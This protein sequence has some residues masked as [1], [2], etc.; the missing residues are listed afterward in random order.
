MFLPMTFVRFRC[1]SPVGPVLLA[2]LLAGCAAPRVLPPAA[3]A[4]PLPPTLPNQSPVSASPAPTTAPAGTMTT[5]PT[6]APTAA[7]SAPSAIHTEW[8]VVQ[9]RT[10][11][12]LDRRR[13]RLDFRPDGRLL[14]HTSCNP[15]T[16][17]YTL[18]GS[19]L[20]VGP[21]ATTKMRCA[22]LQ[23]EQE[24]RLLTALEVAATAVVRSD[25]LLE[26]RDADGR[27]VLRAVRADQPE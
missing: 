6:P 2:A 3:T 17:T 12:M 24:D 16:A 21:V 19:A 20:K 5:T 4:A 9:A 27:G 10:E 23:L 7:P 14:G 18:A 25:G 11:P 8:R 13:A 26:L 15:L 1:P 22:P